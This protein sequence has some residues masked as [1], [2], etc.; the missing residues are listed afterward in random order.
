MLRLPEVYDF[1]EASTTMPVV[2]P[3]QAALITFWIFVVST[4]EPWAGS[5]ALPA[6]WSTPE[7]MFLVS[8]DEDIVLQL[9]VD[10]QGAVTHAQRV[11][12]VFVEARAVT[13]ADS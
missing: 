11:P 7:S 3:L 12:L 6:T 9:P 5:S 10:T 4:V 13:L 8:V 1:P 2:V